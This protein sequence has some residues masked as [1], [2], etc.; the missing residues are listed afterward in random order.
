MDRFLG[1]LMGIALIFSACGP[2]DGPGGP[3]DNGTGKPADTYACNIDGEGYCIFTGTPHETGLKPGTENIVDREGNVLF[4]LNEAL[5]ANS[6]GEVLAARGTPA[7]DGDDLI[8]GSQ[9]GLTD[10]EKAFHRVMA[11][12]YP[13]RNALMYD[14][15]T[16]DQ[17]TWDELVSELTK[18]GIKETTFT[19][20]ATPKDNYHGRQGVFDLAKDPG[21]RDIHHDVMKFLEESSLYL[22]CHVTTDDFAQMLHESHPEG[23]D[24]CADAGITVK[25]LF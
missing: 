2:P 15:A 9:E 24:P 11:T 22:L 19:D 12:M 1:P 3:P 20:G 16:V 25:I 8:Q 6:S 13:I 10:D 17:T 14:I 23:H 21:G 4:P 5:A 7:F 18:R